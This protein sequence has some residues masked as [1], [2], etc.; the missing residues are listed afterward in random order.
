MGFPQELA[1]A[2]DEIE[3]LKI[4]CDKWKNRAEAVVS[5]RMNE[6]TRIKD[7]YNKA[8]NAVQ[9]AVAVGEE[10]GRRLEEYE[11]WCIN[12]CDRCALYYSNKNCP[13]CELNN[14]TVKV[15]NFKQILANLGFCEHGN[16]LPDPD[17]GCGA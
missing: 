8:C 3:R 16:A 11:K 6:L 10:L 15:E 17:C 4:E 2:Q 9:E 1:E 5:V 7:K 14:M 12:W 13:E